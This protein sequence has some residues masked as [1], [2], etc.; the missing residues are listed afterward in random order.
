MPIPVQITDGEA[1]INLVDGYLP[2][3]SQPQL[4][5]GTLDAF[6]RARVSQ[7]TSLFDSKL[8]GDNRPLLWDE[9]ETSGSGTGSVYTL[10]QSSVTMNVTANTAG[11]R[12]RQ[13]FRRFNYQPAK[14]QLI[15]MTFVMGNTGNN[16]TK[17]VGYFDDNNG[18]FLQS[19]DGVT[20]IV[21]R[22]I[23]TGS[24]VDQTIN[25]A[26]WNLDKL[27]GTGPSGLTLDL[28]KVQI[29]QIDFEWL[30]VGRVRWGFVIDGKLVYVHAEN[31]A[32]KLTT[33]YM[34][35][36]NL[37]LRYEINNGGSG[38]ASELVCICASVATEGGRDQL[39]LPRAVSTGVTRTLAGTVNTY[40]MLSVRL[41]SGREDAVIRLSDFQAFC[42]TSDS[43]LV[44]FK[45]N[46]T[47]AGTLPSFTSVNDSPVEYATYNSTH[48]VTG[49]ST[50]YE[51]FAYGRTERSIPVADIPGLG[52]A[53]D[54]TRSIVTVCAKPIST[55]PGVAASIGWRELG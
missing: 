7:P 53:I 8:V 49:G 51:Y 3:A 13:T 18:L 37:P 45:Q 26:D 9:A 17:R 21:E 42:A 41:K 11:T 36:P 12:V 15:L 31:H 47:I 44:S 40:A 2:V 16:I 35:S 20:S 25:Q 43:I 34:R 46:A 22:S 30:G 54:G 5:D 29:I 33:V 39:G 38:E 14:S 23:T 52:T 1:T 19:K 28:T 4:D 50:L 55:N 32:N 48:L 6:G 10:N 27:D 24:V